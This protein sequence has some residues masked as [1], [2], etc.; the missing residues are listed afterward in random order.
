MQ[1]D[2]R[3][4]RFQSGFPRASALLSVVEPGR[5]R[6][7]SNSLQRGALTAALLAGVWLGACDRGRTRAKPGPAAR[8]CAIPSCEPVGH[9]SAFAIRTRGEIA[10]LHPDV[11]LSEWLRDHVR[12]TAQVFS[13]SLRDPT[14][15]DWCARATL[16]DTLPGGAT[17]LRR[18]YFYAP[19]APT[20]PALPPVAEA[21]KIASSR[22]VLGA[23]WIETPLPHAEPSQ[24]TANRFIA[25]MS[26]Q[27]GVAGAPDN[28]LVLGGS[29]WWRP[30]V[31]WRSDSITILGA[32]DHPQ[33]VHPAERLL[34]IAL[35]P[36]STLGRRDRSESDSA[37]DWAIE[38]AERAAHLSG[39]SPAD[40]DRLLA[41]LRI[42][43]GER[44]EDS[45]SVETWRPRLLATL[46]QWLAEAHRRSGQE[47][48]AAL[49]AADFVLEVPWFVAADSATRI[50][51]ESLGAQFVYDRLGGAHTYTHS[52]LREA[53]VFAGAGP[54]RDLALLSQIDRGF[55]DSGMCSAG[56]EEFRRVIAEGEPLLARLD[57]VRDRARVHFLL[58]DAY[59]DIVGLADGIS[60]YAEAEKYRGEAEAAR[61]RSIEHYQQG[62]SLDRMSSRARAAREQARRLAAGLPPLALR[63][64]CVYD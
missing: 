35:L 15:D 37:D 31:A 1:I 32:W 42:E 61:A 60:E 3:G 63:F 9:D 8:D 12:D 58:G 59:A 16:E 34:A 44:G 52:L 5:T 47:R 64:Y 7:L 45:A 55:D 39:M 62:L 49:L 18:A 11:T 30:F 13:Y 51:L 29:A 23:L 26:K 24:L 2:N 38:L 19:T 56:G 21:A 36:R 4:G 40:V 46:R 43:K 20:D 17:V 41:V 48:G 28:H 27:Y 57:D 54:V 25:D 50:Q 6:P 10:A 22:C 53:V 14:H 33:A